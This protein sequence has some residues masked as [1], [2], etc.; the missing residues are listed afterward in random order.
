MTRCEFF[1]KEGIF[2]SFKITGHVGLDVKGKDIVCA[3]I[4]ALSQSTLIGLKEVMK[5]DLDYEL[6][7]GFV[8]C[9]LRDKNECAQ[10]M[11]KTLYETLVQLSKQYPRN[12]VVQ[13]MEVR[14]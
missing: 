14:K 7:E 2:E 5:I 4:S 1:L 12:V 13:E 10:M 8:R 3:A 11:V 9:D 6:K